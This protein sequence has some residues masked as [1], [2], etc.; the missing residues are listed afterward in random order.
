MINLE[1]FKNIFGDCSLQDEKIV[2]T[3]D[4]HR[5]LEFVKTNYSYE[6]LKDII[7]VDKRDKGI[8]LTYH[9]YS[10][11]DDENLLLTIYAKDEAESV[12]DLFKSAIADENEIYDMFGIK[13][14]G[15]ENLKRLYMPENWEGHP[16]K[17]DYS[18]KDSRL[19]WNDD[20]NS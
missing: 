17:K 7:A 13:F 16:L 1:E 6:I 8:E 4:L 11:Q 14:T 9:L 10:L 3:N 20:N 2:I 15:N 19:V 18:E 12:I 5:V